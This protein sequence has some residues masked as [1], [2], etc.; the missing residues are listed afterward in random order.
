MVSAPAINNFGAPAFSA[1]EFDPETF[2]SE[3]KILR[4]SG[5]PLT[6]IA[7]ESDGFT[8]ISGNASINDFGAVAS[9]GTRRGRTAS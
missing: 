2:N 8:S 6:T 5:G 3:D 4:G 1:S 7:D 9:T